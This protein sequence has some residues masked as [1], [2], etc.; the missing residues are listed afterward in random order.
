MKNAPQQQAF[1]RQVGEKIRLQRKARGISQ[2]TLGKL[3]GLTRTSLT[4][5][6]CGRQHPPLHIF[7]EIAA[8]LE[9]SVSELLPQPQAM[10]SGIDIEALLKELGEGKAHRAD[11]LAFIKSA[12][13][14]DTG[15]SHGDTKEKNSGNGGGASS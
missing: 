9:V 2:D 14:L 12:I 15:D 3:V 11:E 1:Y 4:N 5:I 6:E 7:C 13:G 8:Q 10:I